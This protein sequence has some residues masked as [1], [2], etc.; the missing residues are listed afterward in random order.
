MGRKKT[1]EVT[2]TV[3]EAP[4]AERQARKLDVEALRAYADT[5]DGARSSKLIERIDAFVE[6][7]EA[8]KVASAKLRNTVKALKLLED[9]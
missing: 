4:K 8:K 2:E 1:T 6:A 9:E 5:L 7:D 3:T